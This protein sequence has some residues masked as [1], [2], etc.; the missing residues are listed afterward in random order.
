MPG[1]TSGVAL[2][3]PLPPSAGKKRIAFLLPSGDIIS[4]VRPPSLKAA[5]G[6]APRAWWPTLDRL[7]EL[8]FRHSVEARV[9]GSLAWRSLTVDYVTDRPISICCRIAIAIP[10]LTAWPP[11]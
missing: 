2:G 3:L 10:I 5:S 7:G 11:S 8:A 9:F 6:S 1:E 4:V